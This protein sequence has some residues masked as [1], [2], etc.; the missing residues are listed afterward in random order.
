MSLNILHHC[1]FAA[2]HASTSVCAFRFTSFL[3][4]KPVGGSCMAEVVAHVWWDGNGVHQTA[5]Q[6]KAAYFVACQKIQEAVASK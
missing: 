6:N 2:S 1:L 5:E 4:V 3:R